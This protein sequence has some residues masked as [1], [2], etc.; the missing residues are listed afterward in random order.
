[1]GEVISESAV[2]RTVRTGELLCMPK[3]PPGD[4]VAKKAWLAARTFGY[5]IK[6]AYAAVAAGGSAAPPKRP[7]P[8]AAVA[9]RLS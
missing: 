4:A 5:R 6:C 8:A 2:A 9:A 7:R 3:C 1:M